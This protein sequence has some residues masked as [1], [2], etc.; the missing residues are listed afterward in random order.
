M[1]LSV[2]QII[3][4][5]IKWKGSQSTETDVRGSGTGLIYDHLP[6]RTE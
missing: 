4:Y 2:L 3:T 5:S 6:G 1:A